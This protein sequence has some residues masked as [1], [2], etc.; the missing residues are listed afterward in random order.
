MRKSP[1][2]VIIG[3]GSINVDRMKAIL[4][5]AGLDAAT[6]FYRDDESRKEELKIAVES[7]MYKR[8]EQSRSVRNFQNYKATYNDKHKPFRRF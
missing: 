3:G 4:L 2:I 6:S 8:E 1:G 5:N 7:I